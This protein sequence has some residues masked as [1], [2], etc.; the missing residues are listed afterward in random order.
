M[1]PGQPFWI[2]RITPGEWPTVNSTHVVSFLASAVYFNILPDY[3]SLLETRWVIRW[4]EKGKGLLKWIA[5]DLAATASISMAS[6]LLVLA[7]TG[8]PDGPTGPL[9]VVT[10]RSRFSI[11]F[12]TAFF[13][14]VWLWLYG[15]SVL[16]SR[17]LVRVNAG[18]GFLLNVTDVR[19]SP[20]RAVGF[21]SILLV[22]AIF[23]LFLPVVLV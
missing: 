13:T 8:W 1:A 2:Y 19:Q 12:Y 23:L 3:L 16:I 5:F 18:V 21:V 17:L 22:S 15:A 7:A 11:F 10:G 6:V 14:S 9:D 20:L 4:M